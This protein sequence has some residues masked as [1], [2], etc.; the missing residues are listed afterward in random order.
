[1]APARI[2]VAD[3]DAWILRMVATVLGQRGHTIEIA[4]DGEEAYLKALETPP[5]LLICDV[6]MPKMS[7]WDLVK[8]L[9]ARP[10]FAFVPVIFLT[11]LATDEDRIRGFRLGADDYVTK[12]FRF[13]ELDLRV[14]R[15][16]QRSHQAE[17]MA[18]ARLGAATRPDRPA[19]ET[20]GSA[21]PSGLAGRLQE[22]GLPGLLTL[23]EME[24]KSGVLVVIRDE[25]SPAPE[26][27]GDATVAR[28][29]LKEGR[30]HAARVEGRDEPANAECV[31]AL[32]EWRAGR[33][34]FEA[35]TVEMEDE[36]RSST[37][38][39]LMEAARRLDERDAG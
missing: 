30:V 23:L 36:V 22:V 13:E 16:L 11:A 17:Q 35:A 4:S 31:Y 29:F 15:T 12:P 19:S 10:E 37:S 28:V 1:M 8:A 39:L 34:E 6:M 14:K 24:R 2:L 5:D 26:A 18:R 33:F 21:P 20:D 9:R 38:F 25:G 27:T 7:G 32:L 3:D